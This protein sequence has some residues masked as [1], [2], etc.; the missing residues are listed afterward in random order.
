MGK[1][2]GSESYRKEMENGNI[3]FICLEK[4]RIVYRGL[5]LQQKRKLHLRNFCGNGYCVMG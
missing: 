3:A 5:A 4:N 1:N 2:A